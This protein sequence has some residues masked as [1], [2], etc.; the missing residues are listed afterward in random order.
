[1]FVPQCH[2]GRPVAFTEPRIHPRTPGCF[3]AISRSQRI[4]PQSV[5]LV[6]ISQ[7]LIS[8]HAV[9]PTYPHFAPSPQASA[10]LP[11]HRTVCKEEGDTLAQC[12]TDKARL[13]RAL[14]TPRGLQTPTPGPKAA[15]PANVTPYGTNLGTQS[16]ESA[17]RSR[18]LKKNLPVFVED[19][20]TNSELQ[21]SPRR[22]Q[23]GASP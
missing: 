20:Y 13:H 16:K 15:D 14:C 11:S 10:R 6:R 17:A 9:P 19:P 1:M 18:N 22:T 3:L 4:P 7:T 8:T 5:F 23:T 21:V 12:I 2:P